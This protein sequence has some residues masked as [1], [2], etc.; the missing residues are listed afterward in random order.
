MAVALH[1]TSMIRDELPKSD[2]PLLMIP[3]SAP[4]VGSSLAHRTPCTT[5]QHNFAASHSAAK[6]EDRDIRDKRKRT[7]SG[8]KNPHV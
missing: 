7:L 8:G 4:R 5:K 3:T 1:S 6:G 2:R